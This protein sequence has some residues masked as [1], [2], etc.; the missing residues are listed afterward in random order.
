[1]SFRDQIKKGG[2][3]FTGD[4][5][6][7]SYEFTKRFKG[8]KKDGNKLY[9]VPTV[10]MDG[11]DKEIDQHIFFG[12]EFDTAFVI[13]DDGTELSM[14]D[15]SPVSIPYGLPFGILMDSLFAAAD[16]AELDLNEE[17]PDLAA[18]EALSL[19]SLVG[20]RFRFGQRVDEKG[21]AE[22]GKRK[23]DNGKEYDRTN[24]VIEAVLG[25]GGSKSNGKAAGAKGG[26]SKGDDLATEALAV[27][28]SVLGDGSV[29]RKN[30][31]LPVSKALMKNAR[32]DELK[33]MILDEDQQAKWEDAGEINIDKKG[34]LSVA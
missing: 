19:A 13:S 21:T 29:L 30:L 8:E 26:K 34:N 15:D 16:K 28:K 5:V 1:M 24:T 9:F 18:G 3:F 11:S 22:R 6:L 10:K 17:L 2:G 20:R 33:A 32:K 23:A 12:K 7:V 27:L 4:G 14:E 31:S 25:E